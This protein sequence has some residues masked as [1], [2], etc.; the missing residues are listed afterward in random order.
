[1]K[2]IIV[3]ALLGV[4]EAIM[5]YES[6]LAERF[7]LRVHHDVAV[8]MTAGATVLETL[9]GTGESSSKVAAGRSLQFHITWVSSIACLNVL[10]TW[11]LACPKASSP[12]ESKLEAKKSFMI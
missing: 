10:M 3:Q 2:I 5:F 12:R 9:P 7:W 6:C 11:Q 4:Q 1:M 8:K